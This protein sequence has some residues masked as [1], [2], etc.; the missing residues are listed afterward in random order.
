MEDYRI[1]ALLTGESEIDLSAALYMTHFGET[2]RIPNIVFV[3]QG[4]HTI[5]VDTSFDSIERA[6]E[7]HNQTVWRPDEQEVTNAFASAGI[8]PESIEIVVFTHLHYDHC[9]T[10]RLFTNARF[11]VQKR[12]LENAFVPTRGQETAYFSPLVGAVP[13]FMG[14]RFELIDGDAVI[15]PGVRA[16]FTPGHCAGHQS[17]LAETSAGV[18]AVA[19]DAVPCY[20]NIQKNIPCGYHESVDQSYKSMDRIVRE[21]DVVLPS[22]DPKMFADSNIRTYPD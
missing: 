6:A 1:T 2:V 22:H 3:L 18:F 16:I 5:V 4:P 15:A 17:I 10:N 20:E 14:T 12:E 19:G 11:I 21:S 8:D 13:A 7:I 9:G